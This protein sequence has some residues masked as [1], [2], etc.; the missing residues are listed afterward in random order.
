MG[1]GAR[2]LFCGLAAAPDLPFTSST[3]R[4]RSLIN[5]K[6]RSLSN[7]VVVLCNIRADQQC[8]GDGSHRISC[9]PAVLIQTCTIVEGDSVQPGV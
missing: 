2:F 9:L 7:A 8:A 4:A 6:S 5:S 3:Q 1:A